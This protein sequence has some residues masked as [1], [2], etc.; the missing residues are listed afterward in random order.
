MENKTAILLKL[1]K[2][3]KITIEEFEILN[4]KEIAYTCNC[5]CNQQSQPFN[6]FNPYQPT[7]LYYS[8]TT[9]PEDL[10]NTNTLNKEN[11]E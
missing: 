9:N 6:P 10:R 7:I 2:E 8:N 5:N 4:Q 11:N 1:Y 3:D